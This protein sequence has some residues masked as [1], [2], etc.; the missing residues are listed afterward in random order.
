LEDWAYAA[1]FENSNTKCKNIDKS[2]TDYSKNSIRSLLY[3]VEG[4]DI[5]NVPKNLLGNE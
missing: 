2:E 1:T 4:G 5:K 3:L